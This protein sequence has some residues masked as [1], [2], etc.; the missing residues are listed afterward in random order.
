MN[1]D[2]VRKL[3]LF[4][5]DQL[6]EMEAQISTIRLVKILYLIDLEH[7]NKYFETLTGI[8]WIKYEYGP[9]FFELPGILRSARIDLEPTEVL[10]SRGKGITY[11]SQEP[12]DIS[13]IVPFATE[14]MIGRILKKW[15]FEDTPVLLGF[16]YDT[17]PVKHGNY[18]EPLDFTIET[19]NLLLEQA[20][21]TA[22]DFLT[23]D[24]LMA[25][26]EEH[27]ANDG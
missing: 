5:V 1:R 26:Y 27:S 6:Q 10:T 2:L 23:I 14:A 22:T 25:D 7:Y 15:A 20:V 8:D 3:L 9:Y 12:Q 21:K 19:D 16:V 18:R 11:R 17:L 24:E 13:K 4:I